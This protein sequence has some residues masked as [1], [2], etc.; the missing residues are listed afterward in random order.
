MLV[1]DECD[2][3][4]FDMMNATYQPKNM[5][6]WDLEMEFFHAACSFYDRRGAIRM[7]KTFG[8]AYGLT[9]YALALIARLGKWGTWL[10]GV[11]GKGSWYYYLRHIP[12]RYAMDHESDEIGHELKLLRRKDDAQEVATTLAVL[13]ALVSPVARR[14]RRLM[15][16]GSPS[17][18]VRQR[19]C[20]FVS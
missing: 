5:S 12:W 7:G 18:P 3:E 11:V 15:K 6:P 10:A 8:P 2:W 1:R 16:D 4:P 19:D 13:A 14:V 20:P 9:R 17:L